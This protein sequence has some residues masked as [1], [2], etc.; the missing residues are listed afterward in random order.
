MLTAS[1]ALALPLLL[2]QEPTRNIR[3]D[4]RY[5]APKPESLLETRHYILHM[6]G[7][8]PELESEGDLIEAAFEEFS[9]I[10]GK[11]PRTK[12]GDKPIVRLFDTKRAWR[13]GLDLE[14]EVPPS[15]VD[16]VHYSP[17]RKTIYVYGKPGSVWRRKWLLF[18][19]FQDFHRSLK[20]KNRDLELEWYVTGM[21]DAFSTHRWDGETLEL[22]AHMALP[23]NNRAH[24]GVQRGAL[25]KIR[26]GEISIEDLGDWDVR[27]A[28][29][30]FLIYGE[31]G[32]YWK[33]FQRL[34][35]GSTGSM[36]VGSDLLPLVGDAKEITAKAAAWLEQ[37]ARYLQPFVGD[38]DEDGGVLRGRAAAHSYGLAMA[39]EHV[40][41]VQA[42]ITP[43]IDVRVGLVMDWIDRDHFTVAL[44]QDDILFIEEYD[45][46][47]VIN[48]GDYFVKLDRSGSCTIR[49][50]RD[51]T[52]VVL[53]VGKKRLMSMTAY[54]QRMGLSVHGGTAIFEELHWK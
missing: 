50:E 48:H 9:E 12:R 10:L 5:I 21:A 41:E 36:V 45:K 54:G 35:L 46:G 39:D 11:T 19:L 33:K 38:W 26:D 23:A 43:R 32:R 28:L 47:Q 44:V 1:L 27:W 31:D 25:D 24:A 42:K 14:Q 22:A 8:G 4:I 3:D 34:A 17:E 52:E 37:Q 2:A 18:G 6:D 13:E 15:R 20:A 16:F 7:T 30:C 40:R 29:T 51:K 53:S 49:I